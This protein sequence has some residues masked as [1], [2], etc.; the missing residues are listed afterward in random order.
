MIS[1]SSQHAFFGLGVSFITPNLMHVNI[2]ICEVGMAPR[3]RPF[4]G[5]E[6]GQ[7]RGPVP[8]G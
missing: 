8:T 6:N 3:G 5:I 4:P 1:Y 2:V 7:A